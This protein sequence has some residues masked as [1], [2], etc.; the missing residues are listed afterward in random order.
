V[1]TVGDSALRVT[2]A[3]AAAPADTRS[4]K[5]GATIGASAA[6]QRLYPLCERLAASD[7]PLL[8]EGETGTG[9]EVLAESLHAASARAEGPFVVC[10]CTAIAPSLA[11]SAL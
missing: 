3:A 5:F 1:I 9:K 6:M 2:R 4:A 11:E 8:V 10:D 7:V